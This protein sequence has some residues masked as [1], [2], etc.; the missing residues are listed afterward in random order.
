MVPDQLLLNCVLPDQSLLSYQ[1][2]D[3][4]SLRYGERFNLTRG[5]QLS[6][7]PLSGSLGYCRLQ[8][9]EVFCATNFYGT[10]I[11]CF[12]LQDDE[13]RSWEDLY[14]SL[15]ARAFQRWGRAVNG[16]RERG[17]SPG[18]FAR[19][20]DHGIDRGSNCGRVP[21]RAASG[22]GLVRRRVQ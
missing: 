21:C 10:I 9:S 18:K 16:G 7:L 3:A 22:G 1:K 20:G 4:I 17:A 6:C 12:A 13:G 8:C 15:Y 14:R 19:R 2:T 5:G 11:N